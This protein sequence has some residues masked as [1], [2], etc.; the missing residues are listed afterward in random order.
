MLHGLWAQ[1]SSIPLYTHGLISLFLS[2]FVPSFIP[3]SLSSFFLS[4]CLS[5]LFVSDLSLYV[6][7]LLSGCVCVL[8]SATYNG[9]FFRPRVHSGPGWSHLGILNLNHTSKDS[10][11]KYN[12][13][14]RSQGFGIGHIFWRTLNCSLIVLSVVCI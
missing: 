2:F 6:S 8:P 14:M 13:I 11:S 10:Y 9:P 4:L 3:F 12:Y 7:F 1:L 5:H